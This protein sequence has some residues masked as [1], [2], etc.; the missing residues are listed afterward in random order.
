LPVAAVVETA[1]V[2]VVEAV[3]SWKDVHPPRQEPMT[4]L[5]GQVARLVP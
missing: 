4:S 1:T 5:L 2:A 3:V